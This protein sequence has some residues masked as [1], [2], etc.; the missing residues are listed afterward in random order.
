MLHTS[1]IVKTLMNVYLTQV[2]KVYV[3]CIGFK[4]SN[5]GREEYITNVPSPKT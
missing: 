1:T 2:W 3:T 5:G 4:R